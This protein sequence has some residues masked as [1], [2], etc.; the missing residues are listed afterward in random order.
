LKLTSLCH[1]GRQCPSPVAFLILCSRVRER[2]KRAK[3]R[4]RG[5]YLVVH[6]IS[7]RGR[8]E[9]I[10]CHQQIDAQPVLKQ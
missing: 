6:L 3:A 5:R 4:G 10:S 7:K 9:S 1:C 8:R 2:I